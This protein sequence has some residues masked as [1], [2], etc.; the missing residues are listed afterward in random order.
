M[1]DT[2]GKTILIVDDEPDI[3]LYLQTILENAG[4]GVA[5]AGNGNQALNKVTQQKPDAISLDLVMPKMSGLKFFRYI[6]KN[7]DRA[8][9]P[10][11]VVSAHGKDEFGKGDLDKIKKE[12]KGGYIDFV[13]KPV[14]PSL[15]VDAIRKAVGLAALESA[16]DERYS[17]MAKL[18]DEMRSADKTKLKKA[19]DIFGKEK[20]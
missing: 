4:F 18:Q 6:K 16:T 12:S 11:V 13:E 15:Y 2:K 17:L 19:L 8:D 14:K 5:V 9:I 1:E 3:Q 7:K 20:E 10:F